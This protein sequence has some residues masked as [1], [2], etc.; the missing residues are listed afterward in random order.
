MR[1]YTTDDIR[2]A[3][4]DPT[5][6]AREIKRIYG[7]S[8]NTYYGIDFIEE[9]WDNLII[10]DGC[11]A[12]LFEARSEITGDLTTKRSNASGTPEFLEKNFDGKR[13]PDTVYLSA[14]PHLD[15]IEAAFHDV[16]RLW[17]TDWDEETGTVLPNDAANRAIEVSKEYPD[18]RLIVH[19]IQPH[20]PF[21]GDTASQMEQSQLVG[22]GVIL[23]EPEV[24]FWWTSLEKGDL[25]RETAWK[26]YSE[27]LDLTLPHVKRLIDELNG[28]TVVSADHGNA[29]GEDGIYGHPVRTHH[30]SLVDVPWLRIRSGEKQIV[31]AGAE[32]K[33]HE[34]SS[35][36]IEDRLAAL[37]YV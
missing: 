12:D 31:P 15:T 29:F 21:L 10:L 1:S 32:V 4:E 27:T 35:D 6:I 22:G 18:K 19:F 5:S 28:L 13:F 17:E 36:D 37:G 34:R 11:R 2:R 9:E 20:R 25:D 16:V 14:N 26:A 23:D 24:D 30:W 3:V 7:G 33:T 8:K